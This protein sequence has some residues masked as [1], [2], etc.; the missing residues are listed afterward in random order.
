MD[1]KDYEK[2]ENESLEKKD[3]E[4]Q[5]LQYDTSSYEIIDDD[6]SDFYNQNL[7]NQIRD[8]RRQNKGNQNTIS[9]LNQRKANTMNKGVEASK[10]TP[11]ISNEE[12]P[13]EETNKKS[14][15]IS[16]TRK[17]EGQ[18][19]KKTVANAGKA[20]GKAIAKVGS[21]IAVAL[22]T[23]PAFW[24]VVGV[25]LLVM[26]V[27]ILW[28]AFDSDSGSSGGSGT[29]TYVEGYEACESIT[30]EGSGTYPLED[31]VAGVIEHEAYK[32][33]NIEALKAQAVA[34]RTYAIYKTNNCT[35]SIENSQF[36]QTFSETPSDIAKSAAT[37]TSG[38]VLTYNDQVFL[39]E[40]DSFCYEDGRCPDSTKNED[41]TYTVT[42]TR[43]PNNETHK[44]TLSQE[45][46]YGR[47]VIAAGHAHGMSQLVSYQMASEGK[48][49]DEILKFFYSDG[50]KISAISE[51]AASNY[52]ATG[53]PT[54]IEELK[55]RYYFTY[56]MDAYASSE[57][58]DSHLFGQCVW[59]AKHRAMDIVSSS[60]LS[61]EEKQKRINSIN[62]TP[63]NGQDWYANM[64]SSI[65]NKT[66]D[67]D[68]IKPGSV[69][70]WEY[71]TYGHVG[72][73]EDVKT[74]ADGNKIFVL[75]DGGRLK[76]SAGNWYTVT[77]NELWSVVKFW[78]TPNASR[79]I[80][81]ARWSGYKFIGAVSL[82][83]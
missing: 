67:I 4:E 23:N 12:E 8:I 60:D 48:K 66:T 2:F 35:T 71:S 22:I 24:V 25:F 39:S 20:V 28:A 43:Q 9:K 38:Q 50:V 21:K 52:S 32:D 76:N 73:I 56:D 63:G 31:Y 61:D 74:D 17:A 72:I 14:D 40:Y 79:N 80:I 54:T 29:I 34:A 59:Y 64:D 69:I 37:A 5:Y 55:N 26:L 49:Y 42:Y 1:N 36:S 81:E 58:P 82:I 7:N 65:F 70:S 19:V 33:E 10:S 27:P 53:I 51:T 13:E 47:I 78:Y 57:G 45:K 44:I 16:Q 18:N 83:D 77:R 75:T 6:N 46:Q 62:S 3:S 41:G 68:K 11:S 15:L 30:V